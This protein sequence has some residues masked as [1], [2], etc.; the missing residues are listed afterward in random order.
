MPN[1]TYSTAINTNNQKFQDETFFG[2]RL[3]SKFTNNFE[4]INLKSMLLEIKA[5]LDLLI[6]H[7]SSVSQIS[8]ITGKSRQT[9]TSNLH[10]NFEP[11]V[12]Y[13]KEN[14]KICLSKSTA[15]KLLQQYHKDNI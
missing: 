10:S 9:I 7:K 6:P 3:E 15:L 13:W 2:K 14:A 1:N 12:D 11:E 4:D 8:L 5:T